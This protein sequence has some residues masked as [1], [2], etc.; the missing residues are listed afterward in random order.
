MFLILHNFHNCLSFN[1]FTVLSILKS[2]DAQKLIEWRKYAKSL[3]DNDAKKRIKY[4][5]SKYGVS[6]VRTKK[7]LDALLLRIPTEVVL[8]TIAVISIL[9][10]LKETQ[11]PLTHFKKIWNIKIFTTLK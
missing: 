10:A 11:M 8:E 4:L 5:I 1:Y 9:W 6:F 7:D 3:H 2:K